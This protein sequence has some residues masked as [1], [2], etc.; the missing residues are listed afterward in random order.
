MSEQT[1]STKPNLNINP[2]KFQQAAEFAAKIK[3]EAGEIG[4]SMAAKFLES[5]GE[6][7]PAHIDWFLGPAYE[8][9]PDREGWLCVR[10]NNGEWK[11]LFFYRP[12]QPELESIEEVQQIAQIYV[13][14][15]EHG[16]EPEWNLN[17]VLYGNFNSD[18]YLNQVSEEDLERWNGD[19]SQ[20][21]YGLFRQAR[22]D[23][24]YEMIEEIIAKRL[25]NTALDVASEE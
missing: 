6:P 13:Q 15:R 8:T 25:D 14:S 1:G 20:A 12:L 5:L 2:E 17:E 7:I 4:E 22:D 18:D 21:A 9:R 23:A 3:M 10:R 16:Q 11:R 19:T 24:L